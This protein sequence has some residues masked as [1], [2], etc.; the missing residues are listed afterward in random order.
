MKEFWR[1]V[2]GHFLPR[3]DNAYRPHMLRKPWLLF[4]LTVVLTSEAIYVGTLSLEQASQNNLSAVLS[5]EVI[6]LTNAER[7]NV[8]DQVL[9]ENA[10]LNAAAQAKAEDMATRGYFSHVGPDGKE[11]WTWIKE[12]GYAYRFAG[13][14]LAVRFE[15]SSDVV[16]AWMASP[17][18]K[19][20]IVKSAY[21]EIGVGVAQ[22]IYEGSPATFVVQYFGTKPGSLAAASPVQEKMPSAQTNPSVAGAETSDQSAPHASSTPIPPSANAEL[23]AEQTLE[24]APDN[25]SVREATQALLDTNEA[26]QNSALLTIGG[27]AALLIVLVGLA[28]FVHMEIQPVEMLAGGAIIAVVAISLFTINTS[29]ASRNSQSAAAI[30]AQAAGNIG[31]D[32]VSLSL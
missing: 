7:Q 21:Q 30:N 20:N 31:E 24:S 5:G 14:N 11:P 28:F 19:A 4:F 29:L 22:G 3:H 16:N 2:S 23:D 9:V 15:N 18:H 17:T 25:F 13:E 26:T 6:A 12:S 10:K 8:G 32:G 1:I 27:V